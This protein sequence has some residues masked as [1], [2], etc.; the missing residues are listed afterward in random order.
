MADNKIGGTGKDGKTPPTPNVVWDDTD[1]RMTYANVVNVSSTREEIT[2]FFGTN[3]TWNASDE[4]Y[5]VKLS[6][7]IVLNPFAA[8]RLLSLLA[9]MLKEYEKR[10]GALPANPEVPLAPPGN[11][12]SGSASSGSG[13]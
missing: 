5:R 8:R 1:L 10:F 7:R 9:N 3:L 6:D 12:S 13:S 2:L 11:A 4:E